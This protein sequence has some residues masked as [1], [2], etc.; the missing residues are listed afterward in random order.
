MSFLNDLA[1][2]CVTLLV[3]FLNVVEY[4]E[5][6]VEVAARKTVQATSAA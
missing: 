6:V 5:R 3:E 2:L 1:K 4:Y